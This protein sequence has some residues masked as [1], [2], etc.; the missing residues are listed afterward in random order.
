MSEQEKQEG[1]SRFAGEEH[2][3]WSPDVGSGGSERATEANEKAFS[4]PPEGQGPGRNVS[5][6]E[7]TG[8][9]DT[10]MEPDSALGVGTDRTVKHGEDYG[11]EG[12]AGE[13]TEGT[14][15][16]SQ[17][18]Y[19]TVDPDDAPERVDPESPHLPPGDQGG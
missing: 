1:P 8:V 2:H 19:G 18:P 11:R 10:D 5:E 4:G 6:E 7:R 14:K 17:R 13:S 9:S 15:G 16:A 3:G 12:D